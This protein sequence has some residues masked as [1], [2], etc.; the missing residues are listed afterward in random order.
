MLLDILRRV[1]EVLFCIAVFGILFAP[2]FL[3]YW[4]TDKNNMS[5]PGLWALG[6]FGLGWLILLIGVLINYYVKKVR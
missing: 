4:Y 3:F 5:N 2:M 1:G 6:G